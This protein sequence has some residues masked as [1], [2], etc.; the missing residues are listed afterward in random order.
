MEAILHRLSQRN[1][2]RVV[3]DNEFHPNRSTLSRRISS[4]EQGDV[5]INHAGFDEAAPSDVAFINFVREPLERSVSLFY[6][7]VDPD[8]RGIQKAKECLTIREKDKHCGCAN[9][10]ANEC[11]RS[12][13]AEKCSCASGKK[14]MPNYCRPFDDLDSTCEGQGRHYS[15]SMYF[16]APP[17]NDSNRI[18]CDA[19][20]AERNVRK[21]YTLVGLVE[22]FE[23][24]VHL[25]E[26]LLP[27]WFAGALEAL[28]SLPAVAYHATNEKN[29]LTQTHLNRLTESARKVLAGSSF[30]QLAFYETVKSLLWK[31]AGN[32]NIQRML[33]LRQERG[34]R[35]WVID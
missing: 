28:Y 6:Y 26:R 14:N 2:F 5:Y 24:S 18:E 20:T 23:L 10:G 1:N 27:R 35:D 7:A 32:E 15:Q 16:C 19:R 13:A 34:K 8:S 33:Q 4:L 3:T 11:V 30:N 31:Q 29:N 12:Q 17:T 21:R 9:L 22:E 25:L